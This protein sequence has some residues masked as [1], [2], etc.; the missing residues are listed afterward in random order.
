MPVLFF[1]YKRKTAELLSLI[2]LSNS[3]S[4]L[5]VYVCISFLEHSYGRT[6]ATGECAVADV[7]FAESNEQLK[8]KERMNG[9]F[10]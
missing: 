6:S 8:M 1:I 9:N 2:I 7:V 5:E 4:I 3:I 10:Y